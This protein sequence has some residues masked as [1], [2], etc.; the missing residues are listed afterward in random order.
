VSPTAWRSHRSSARRALLDY[1]TPYGTQLLQQPFS[2]TRFALPVMPIIDPLDTLL[3]TA[4]VL[5]A[6]RW[7]P[8]PRSRA[9]SLIA[10][11]LSCG[12][13]GCAAHLNRVA[14]DIATQQLTAMGLA[15]LRY[16]VDNDPTNSDPIS[17]SARCCTEPTRHACVS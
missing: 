15:D 16:G 8:A 11:V 2:N 17:T 9:A 3:L 4:G 13:I 7:S 6:W 5:L 10:V 1:L 14:R 12:Y